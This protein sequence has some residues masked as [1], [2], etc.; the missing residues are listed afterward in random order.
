MR[1]KMAIANFLYHFHN[2]F[3]IIN[4]ILCIFSEMV[5]S[6]FKNDTHTKKANIVKM[7][8]LSEYNLG[9]K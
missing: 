6:D 9:E 5:L 1:K 3:K 7:G 8:N 2:V 4:I